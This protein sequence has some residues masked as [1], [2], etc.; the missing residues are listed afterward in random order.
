M[1]KSEEEDLTT[2]VMCHEWMKKGCM[3]S[4]AMYCYIKRRRKRGSPPKKWI[5]NIKE[6]VKLLELSIGEAV[7]LTRDREKWRSL[8]ATS[9]SANG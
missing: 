3:P 9:L 6:D 8:V 4:R 1:I 2:S 7:N 5:D